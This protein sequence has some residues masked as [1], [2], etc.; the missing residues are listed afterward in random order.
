MSIPLIRRTAEE[1]ARQQDLHQRLAAA[2]Y[3][4]ELIENAVQELAF[5]D[6]PDPPPRW[7]AV[8]RH[9]AHARAAL[10]AVPSLRWPIT[11]PPPTVALAIDDPATVTGEL[12]TLAEV[13]TMALLESARQA[14]E[15]HDAFATLR[16]TLRVHGLCLELHRSRATSSALPGDNHG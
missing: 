15:P 8:Q 1:L 5:L 6:A 11:S 13:L 10:A 12:L 3:A 14:S 16:A 7:A 9:V 4:L 2:Y